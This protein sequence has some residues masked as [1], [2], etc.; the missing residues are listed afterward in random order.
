MKNTT[1]MMTMTTNTTMMHEDDDNSDNKGL[2]KQKTTYREVLLTLYIKTT[3][4]NEQQ[5]EEPEMHRTCHDPVRATI[6]H[7]ALPAG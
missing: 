2:T 1:T 4:L 5:R 6:A 3:D 7:Q